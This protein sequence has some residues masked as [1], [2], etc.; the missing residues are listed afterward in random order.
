ML[1]WISN[2]VFFFFVWKDSETKSWESSKFLF[3]KLALPKT[4]ISETFIK[5]YIKNISFLSNKKSRQNLCFLLYCF[6][7]NFCWIYVIPF[8]FS[9]TASPKYFWVESSSREG[10]WCCWCWER[11]RGGNLIW[12]DLSLKNSPPR[13]G[14]MGWTEA[15]KQRTRR[16]NLKKSWRC[17]HGFNQG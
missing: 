3:K 12:A 16:R 5:I 9:L 10:W 15:G 8:C 14:G 6:R 13:R 7:A 11:E 17:I 2:K 4:E 1:E